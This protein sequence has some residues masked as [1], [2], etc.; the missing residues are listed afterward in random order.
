LNDVIGSGLP[1]IEVKENE[2]ALLIEGLRKVW[3]NEL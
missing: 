2:W 3:V 1:S